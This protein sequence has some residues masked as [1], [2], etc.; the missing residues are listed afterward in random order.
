VRMRTSHPSIYAK[1][2]LKD[3]KYNLPD[4]WFSSYGSKTNGECQLGSTSFDPIMA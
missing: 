1:G 4:K 2:K 3:G